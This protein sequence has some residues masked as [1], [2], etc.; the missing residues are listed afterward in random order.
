MSPDNGKASAGRVRGHSMYSS[1]R[2]TTHYR[3]TGGELQGDHA[4]ISAAHLREHASANFTRGP[5]AQETKTPLLTA[6]LQVAS[7]CSHAIL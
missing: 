2:A 5:I 1:L 7:K 4:G 3:V 6:A